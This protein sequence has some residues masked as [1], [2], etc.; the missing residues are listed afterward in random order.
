VDNPQNSKQIC[1]RSERDVAA[2]GAAA[3]VEGPVDGRGE[4]VEKSAVVNS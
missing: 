2:I 1:G 3:D 4:G